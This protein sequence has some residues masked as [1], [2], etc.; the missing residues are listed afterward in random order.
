VIKIKPPLVLS[1]TD[2]DQIVDTLDAA[3]AGD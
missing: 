1:E 3:L 2:A